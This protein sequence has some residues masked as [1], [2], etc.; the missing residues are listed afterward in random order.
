MANDA[1]TLKE[2]E[3]VQEI[4][5]GVQARQNMFCD[6]ILKEH[7]VWKAYR[8]FAEDQF[9]ILRMLP[10]MVSD[11]EA[12]VAVAD[13]SVSAIVTSQ[14]ELDRISAIEGRR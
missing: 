1:A 14:M 10:D 12:K 2:L 5:Q 8:I 7:D 9:Q 6:A 3:Q 13:Y 4:L 11:P